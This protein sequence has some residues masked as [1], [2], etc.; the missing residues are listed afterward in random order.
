M[1]MRLFDHQSS[2]VKF[3]VK[4]GGIGAIYHSMGL[5]KTLT[6]LT[7][8][9]I[10]KK[11]DADLKLFVVCPLSLIEGAWA[12]DIN[13][14]TSYTYCNL[15]DK[16]VKDA[17]IYILNY[18]GLRRKELY[19]FFC[20]YK[21]MIVLDESSK[22][23]N[24]KSQTTKSLLNVKPLFK[25]RIVMSGT[26]APNCETEYWAQMQFVDGN[27]FHKS[28]YA[29]QNQYFHLARGS[30]RIPGTVACR[31]TL[32][33]MFSKGWKYEL[34]KENRDKLIKRMAPW[35]HYARKED[36]LDLPEKIDELR[37][38]ELT[39][40]QKQ[41]Y[42]EMKKLCITEIRGQDIAA[43][44]AL[45]KLMKLRQILSGFVLDKDGKPL[46]IGENAKMRELVNV[47]EEAGDQKIIIWGNFQH[48]IEKIADTLGTDAVTL[49]GKTKNRQ[50]VIDAFLTGAPK[51]LVAN[52]KT[53]GHGL[54]FVNC[55]LE[56][57]YSLDYSWESYAQARDRVHRPGQKNAC[58]YIH[59][60]GR[61][62]IDQDIYKVL[63]RKGDAADIVY[64][65]LRHNK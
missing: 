13:K 59:L 23:K 9:E 3:I 15:H 16:K 64:E 12:V 39:G 27:I 21:F 61:D 22:I 34:T 35:C 11:K 62:T 36:C 33:E 37:V 2:A 51:Y 43:N 46:E 42:N 56:I 20:R 14:F 31:A 65:F 26:P 48:E 38:V 1:S 54:T 41:H 47:I 19:K 24:H 30:Q 8:Y 49:Y 58:T 55:S 63:Q 45:T 7:C 57:F 5:G 50:E 32:R 25:Y 18:E 28:F 44:I 40:K 10:F 60:L 4:N 17:D 53:A 52:P 6:A 29:F